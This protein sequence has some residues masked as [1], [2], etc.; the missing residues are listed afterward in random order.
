MDK[1]EVSKP[2]RITSGFKN[3]Q[4]RETVGKIA[5]DLRNEY[6]ADDVAPVSDI[7]ENTT[8]STMEELWIAVERGRQATDITGSFYVCIVQRKDKLLTNVIRQQFFYRQSC[9]TPTYLTSVFFYDR[10]NDELL[11]HWSLPSKERCFQ[12]YNNKELVPPEEYQ[13]LSFVIDF[14]EGRLDRTAQELNG[15]IKPDPLAIVF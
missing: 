4:D 5:L 15:E 10:D 3:K 13:L 11:Y 8:R 2:K 6:K 9:P 14:F 1:K 12:M 7:G